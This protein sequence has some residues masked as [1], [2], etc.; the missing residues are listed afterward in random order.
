MNKETDSLYETI[1]KYLAGHL[2]ASLFEKEFTDLFDFSDISETDISFIYFQAV[3]NL[4]EHYSSEKAD[5]KKY[6]DYYI[7]NE[8]LKEEIIKLGKP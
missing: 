8:K 4:L 6:P 3:R 2:S 1:K 7:S 5:I